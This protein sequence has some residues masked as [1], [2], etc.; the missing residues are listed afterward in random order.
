VIG[1]SVS[2]Y[3]IR[4]LIGEGGMGWV[5]LAE[6]PVTRRKAAVKVVRREFAEDAARIARFIDETRALN[7]LGNPGIIQV[8]DAGSMEHGLPYVLMEYLEGETLRE[9]L[10]RKGR[11]PLSDARAI[12]AP[13]ALAL[14]AAHAKGIV[15]GGLKP[16]NVLLL[17]DENA[18]RTKLMDFGVVRLRGT[19]SLPQK[20]GGFSPITAAY[21]APEQCRRSAGDPDARTDVYALGT[22]LYEML[23]GRPPFQADGYGDVCL[24]QLMLQPVPPRSLVPEMPRAIETVILRTLAKAPAD[25]FSSMTELTKALADAASAPPERSPV[26]RPAAETPTVVTPPVQDLRTVQGVIEMRDVPASVPVEPVA[27]PSMSLAPSLAPLAVMS[28]PSPRERG[29]PIARLRGRRL[30][31]TLAGA[32]VLL[33]AVLVWSRRPPQAPPEQAPAPAAAAPARPAHD[34]KHTGL[35]PP[36][37]P[38]LPQP[39]PILELPAIQAPRRRAPTVLTEAGAKPPP[40]APRARGPRLDPPLGSRPRPRRTPENG[41][42]EKW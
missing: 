31:V 21:M 14:G 33:A 34:E 32:M 7:A 1:R 16:E 4:R 28:A 18:Q 10:R 13:V 24:M 12:F 15:H 5:Y 17:V 30:A 38:Q 3:E 41:W 22:M 35:S 19:T 40:P 20:A 6:H 25:R 26:P 37:S 8:I 23:C 11:L 42:M 27:L 39:D 2:N 36:P 29:L 9:R